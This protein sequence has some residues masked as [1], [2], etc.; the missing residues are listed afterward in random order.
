MPRSSLTVSMAPGLSFLFEGLPE[1]LLERVR[2]SLA[3]FL[4]PGREQGRA[5]EGP[6]RIRVVTEPIGPTSCAS[7]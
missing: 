3:F 7:R 5:E 1:A 2:S 4:R 6:L